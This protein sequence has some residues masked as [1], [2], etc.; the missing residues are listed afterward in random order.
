MITA[1]LTNETGGMK[2][3]YARR[4]IDVALSGTLGLELG[5]GGSKTRER[6]AVG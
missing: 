5:L 2:G 6:H 3:G 4:G 1:R